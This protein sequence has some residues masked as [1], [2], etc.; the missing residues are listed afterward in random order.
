MTKPN[1]GG[2]AKQRNL[3]K[4]GKT[5]PCIVI[6]WC[7]WKSQTMEHNDAEEQEYTPNLTNQYFH[8]LTIF[9]HP[10]F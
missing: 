5:F 2:E 4:K 7:L 3:E 9:P 1:D 10:H 6:R 8:S